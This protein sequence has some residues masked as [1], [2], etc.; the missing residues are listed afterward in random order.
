M[1]LTEEKMLTKQNFI[2]NQVKADA[3]FLHDTLTKAHFIHAKMEFT[4]L[5]GRSN[6]SPTLRPFLLR[7]VVNLALSC[8]TDV[9]YLTNSC[10]SSESELNNPVYK[11]EQWNHDLWNPRYFVERPI[12]R[13]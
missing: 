7:G 10:S 2:Q 9:R 13:T 5:E 11:R 4:A 3:V 1:Q 6:Q 8:I 12:P